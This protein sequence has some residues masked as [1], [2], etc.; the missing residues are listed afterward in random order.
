MAIP[1]YIIGSSN[2]DMVVKAERL[3]APGETILG[4]TFLMN[5]GGKG[6]NQAVAA[7]R[8]G[9]SVTLVANVG[10]DLF[11]KQSIL[12]FKQ[13]NINTNY[14][15]VDLVNPS[16][17]ALINVNA[18]G[19]NCIAVAPGANGQLTPEL[20]KTFF[21]DIKSP[22]IALVQ[23]EIPITT[24][25]YIVE[26]CKQRSIPVILNPAPAHV[27]S[28]EVLR[29]VFL[30]TPNETEAELL[31]GI[32][33]TNNASAQKAARIFHEIGIPNVVLTL[34]ERGAYWSSPKGSGLVSVPVVSA[35][36]TTAAGDCFNGAMAVA[37][38]EERLL[39]DAVLFACRAASIS[40]TR[41]GAQSS[42][43][44]RKE[45]DAHK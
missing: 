10:N 15:S 40:V 31:T 3:P 36:D 4:G 8:L 35:M 33:I 21:E 18:Q 13:E 25:E 45:V 22:A 38:A 34:G 17:V 30:I 19:E 43:P 28:K 5:A 26:Q 37:L 29:N 6:A 39:D 9:G 41:M 23:L 27:L 42:M 11:G 20:L 24:V 12:Q 7:A 1:I 14:I 32:R 16:G 2:T 44:T